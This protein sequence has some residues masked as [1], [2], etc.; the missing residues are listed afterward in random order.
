MSGSSS[1]A[2]NLVRTVKVKAEKKVYSLPGQ[3]YAVLEER[4]PLRIFYESLSKQKP[5]SEMAEFW[6]M[7]HGM[8]S[9]ERAKKAYEKKQKRQKQQRMGTP[10]K[11]EISKETS[12]SSKKSSSA[13]NDQR[14]KK[15]SLEYEDGD[16]DDLIMKPSKAK[17]K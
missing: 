8:L 2:A 12:E 9:P 5:E 10:I 3:K 16:D 4:E 1:T 6:L 14:T 15:R 13:K 11:A 17:Q 7:E